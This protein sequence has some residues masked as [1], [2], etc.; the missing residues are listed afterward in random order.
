MAADKPQVVTQ[1]LPGRWGHVLATIRRYW[2]TY[3]TVV[4]TASLGNG[5]W[6]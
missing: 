6:Q 1:C 4:C 5:V 3:G 2:H